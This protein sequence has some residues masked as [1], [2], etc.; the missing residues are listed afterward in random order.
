MGIEEWR[1]NGPGSHCK[2]RRFTFGFSRL[3]STP[4]GLGFSSVVECLPSKCK[5]LG[6]VPSSGKKEKK[7][8]IPSLEWDVGEDM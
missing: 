1:G 2:H 8:S 4:S 5:A 7:E 3:K 6:L